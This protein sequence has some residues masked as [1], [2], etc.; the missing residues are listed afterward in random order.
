[1]TDEDYADGST[2]F[3]VFC[4]GGSHAAGDFGAAFARGDFGDGIGGAVSDVFAGGFQAFEGF[5][6]GGIDL[7][8]TRGAV[9]A[10]HA[11]GQAAQGCD[12]LA[13]TI[14]QVLGRTARSSW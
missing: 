5:G 2:E 1:M 6:E 3:D 4:F 12:R 14:S 13:G 7:A 10:L 9:A 11:S 8:G